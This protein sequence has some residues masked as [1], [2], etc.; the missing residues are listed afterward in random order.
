[1]SESTV[2]M[3]CLDPAVVS[4]ATS[5]R[6]GRA[7]PLVRPSACTLVVAAV[8]SALSPG[9]AAAAG[10]GDT[11]EN[12]ELRSGDEKPRFIPGFG[13]RVLTIFYTD[14]DVA[15][16]NDP[17]ADALKKRAIDRS[18]HE[19]IGVANLRDSFAPNFIIAAVVRDKIK[20]YDSTILLDPDVKLARA[21]GLGPCN[22]TS[23]VVVVGQDKQIKY[24]RTGPVRGEEIAKVVSLIETLTGEGPKA[25]AAPEQKASGPSADAG[26]AV[27]DAGVA[28]AV[29]GATA[30]DAGLAAA[31]AGATAADAGVGVR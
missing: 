29:A 20:K 16:M 24:V 21:W 26:A 5:P 17:L 6:R 28:P 3:S 10:V 8:L 14:A 13:E 7:S 18:K 2:W 30:A 22:N 4:R 1:M 27:A 9:L 23:V 25:P 31:A 11:V 15:D 19:G 12:V